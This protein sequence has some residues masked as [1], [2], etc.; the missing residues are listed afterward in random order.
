MKELLQLFSEA[1]AACNQGKSTADFE[2]PF[3][4]LLQYIK[5]HPESRNAAEGRF[6]A[7]LHARTTPWELISFCMHELRWE[8]VRQAIEQLMRH[9]TDPRN[10]RVLRLIVESFDDQWDERQ[11]YSY[12]SRS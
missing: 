11:L 8:P 10:Q 2:A 1:E 7:G 3:V 5:E 6:L 12:Y 4:R 9:A